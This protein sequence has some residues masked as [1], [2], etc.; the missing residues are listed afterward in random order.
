VNGNHEAAFFVIQHA[1]LA[2]MERYKDRLE[3]SYA[4]GK[5]PKRNM[6]L[7]YQRLEFRRAEQHQAVP[8]D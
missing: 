1:P 3:Q 8:H 5:I 6:E 7:F 2:Y 4:D